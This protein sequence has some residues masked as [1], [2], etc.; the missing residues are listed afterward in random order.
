MA[1]GI[2]R[3]M[4]C[5]P[6]DV[7]ATLADGWLYPVWVVGAARMRAVS[8]EW[9]QQG[10]A[11]H[12]SLGLWPVLIDDTTEIVSWSPPR[13]VRLRAQAGPFGRAV[14]VIDVREHAEGCVVRMG[15]EPVAG[16]ARLLPRVLWAPLLRAR[17]RETLRRLGFLAEGRRRERDAGEQTARDEVPETQPADADAQAQADVHAATDAAADAGAP[18]A[19]DRSA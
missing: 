1:G 4:R 7:F 12:H 16:A 9:P 10:S 15:E 5:T 14:V 13:R 3:V 6:D 17:N 11:L 18:P 8:P 19:G 2:A